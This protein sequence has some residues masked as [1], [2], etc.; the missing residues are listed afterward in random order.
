M[1]NSK[2][3]QRND[4]IKKLKETANDVVVA[5]KRQAE[6]DEQRI[7]SIARAACDSEWRQKIREAI[8]SVKQQGSWKAFLELEDALLGGKKNV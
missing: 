5:A 6:R 1:M 3:Q 8:A 4:E 2:N 7:I